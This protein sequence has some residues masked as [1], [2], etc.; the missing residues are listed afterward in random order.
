MDT[1]YLTVDPSSHAGVNC[2]LL[3]Q[4]VEYTNTMGKEADPFTEDEVASSKLIA[5]LHNKKASIDTYDD[6]CAWHL[7]AAGQRQQGMPLRECP[8]YVSWHQLLKKLHKQKTHHFR[9]TRL[10][11]RTNTSKHSKRCFWFLRQMS[12]LSTMMPGNH[13]TLKH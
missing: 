2:H 10:T 13:F 5:L 4:F 7:E 3:E 6:V 11:N 12:M 9:D 8:N 1:L